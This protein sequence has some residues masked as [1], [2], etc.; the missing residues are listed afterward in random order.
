MW[1]QGKDV[2]V[3]PLSPHT[4]SP[5]ILRTVYKTSPPSNRRECYFQQR[6]ARPC[7]QESKEYHAHESLYFAA[8]HFIAHV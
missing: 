6:L 1:H 3:T 8:Q 2:P 4:Q 5:V 7:L